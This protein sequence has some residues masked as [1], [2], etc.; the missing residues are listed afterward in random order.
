MIL[1]EEFDSSGLKILVS[2]DEETVGGL[3][4]EGLGEEPVDSREAI[5]YHSSWCL[6]FGRS[7]M[8]YHSDLRTDCR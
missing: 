8:P 3:L 6:K 5:F 2:C 1:S 4:D 7:L